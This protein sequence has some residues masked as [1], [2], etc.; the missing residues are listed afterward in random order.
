MIPT[1]VGIP[2]AQCTERK[3]YRMVC[4]LFQNRRLLWQT[5]LFRLYRLILRAYENITYVHR[6]E[7]LVFFSLESKGNCDQA[8]AFSDPYIIIE[9][10]QMKG[11]G[12]K[13]P[14]LTI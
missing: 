12:L 3:F 2:T 6:S 14:V 7:A 10:L 5:T 8:L 4:K 9:S 13:R 1:A 11:R